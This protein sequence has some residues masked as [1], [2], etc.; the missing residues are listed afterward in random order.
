MKHEVAYWGCLVLSGVN[1]AADNILFAIVWWIL[2]V[3]ILIGD[4]RSE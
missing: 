2:A 4:R 1:V 3:V